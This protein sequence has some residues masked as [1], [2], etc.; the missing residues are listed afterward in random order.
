M[1]FWLASRNANFIG[2]IFQVRVLENLSIGLS[3]STSLG[4]IS[5]VAP[6]SYEIMMGVVPMGLG[7]K[8]K[9]G[10]SVAKCPALDF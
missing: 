10:R 8:Y 6:N 3:Y 4:K 9:G 7:G 2:A 5:N 1:G